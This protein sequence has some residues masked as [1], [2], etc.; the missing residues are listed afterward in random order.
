MINDKRQEHPLID[1]PNETQKIRDTLIDIP[2]EDSRSLTSEL[3][4]LAGPG[5]GGGFGTWV[6]FGTG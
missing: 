5:F 2:N 3:P 6:L 1:I 4:G